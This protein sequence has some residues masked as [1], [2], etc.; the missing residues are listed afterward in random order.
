MFLYKHFVG[1]DETTEF[2]DICR[3]LSFLLKTKRGCG[4]FMK[5]Y[6]LSD[7]GYRTP[8][9]MVTN[10]SAELEENIR[11]YEPRVELLAVD[12]EYD[13]AGKRVH[14]VVNMRM[15]DSSQKLQIVVDLT[16]NTFDVRAARG[17]AKK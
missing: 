8:E 5:T 6:G 4:Y 9:E 3:N 16:K 14:L 1:G 2:D 13:D 10:L 17:K 15:R 7:V 12:E 11:L